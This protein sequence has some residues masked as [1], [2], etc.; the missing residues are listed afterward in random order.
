MGIGR[1]MQKRKM[2]A[3]EPETH[4]M[5]LEYISNIKQATGLKITSAS[6]YRAAVLEK[7]QRDKHKRII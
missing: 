1:E 6:F 4:T 7:L 5:V 3:I 2:I